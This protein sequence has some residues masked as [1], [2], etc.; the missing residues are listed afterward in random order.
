M[1]IFRHRRMLIR[2]LFLETLCREINASIYNKPWIQMW[3]T[4]ISNFRKA[5]CFLKVVS[6]NYFE[7]NLALANTS[8]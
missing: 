5:K 4:A 7:V 2:F 6:Y 3:L 8:G 1:Q